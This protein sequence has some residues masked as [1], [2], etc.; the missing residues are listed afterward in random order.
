MDVTRRYCRNSTK[1]AK[2]RNKCSESALLHILDEIRQMRRRS[3]P[4]DQKFKLQGEDM[5]ESRELRH[6]FFSTLTVELSKSYVPPKQLT[7]T[8]LADA[9]KA[10]ERREQ[11]QQLEAAQNA[12]SDL[13]TRPAKDAQRHDRHEEPPP[14]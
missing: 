12:S 1:H 10:A 6:Y 4:K 13:P 2:E 5:H 7:A 8:E 9:Q 14:R 3:M 11:R